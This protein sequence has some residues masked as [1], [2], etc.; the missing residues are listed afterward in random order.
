[1]LSLNQVL[2]SSS[3]GVL[4]VLLHQMPRLDTAVLCHKHVDSEFGFHVLLHH[5]GCRKKWY[6]VSNECVFDENIKDNE[7]VHIQYH[8]FNL[9]VFS[10]LRTLDA[11]R[12]SGLTDDSNW[13][14]LSRL[15]QSKIIA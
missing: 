2:A 4:T 6:K 12:S 7:I 9:P 8:G 1:M 10:Q 14:Y 15:R 13:Y 3:F 5:D 11:I